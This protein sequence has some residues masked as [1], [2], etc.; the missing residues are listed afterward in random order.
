MYDR[1][2]PLGVALP[3]EIAALFVADVTGFLDAVAS[4]PPQRDADQAA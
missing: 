4:F 3:I 1:I 2:V